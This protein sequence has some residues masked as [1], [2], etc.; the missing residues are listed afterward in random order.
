MVEEGVV[1]CCTEVLLHRDFCL[2]VLNGEFFAHGRFLGCM[3]CM[4]GLHRGGFCIGGVAGFARG[5][6]LSTMVGLAWG[7]VI[8]TVGTFC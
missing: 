6:M 7:C 2:G 1:Q 8:T 4:R 3:V 5:Y